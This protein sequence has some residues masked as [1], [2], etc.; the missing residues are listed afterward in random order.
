MLL[1]ATEM[2]RREDMDSVAAVLSRTVR[3]VLA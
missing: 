1:C 3:S 2:T